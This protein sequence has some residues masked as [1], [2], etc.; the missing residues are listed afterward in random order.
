M[1]MRFATAHL[2]GGVDI[3][4]DRIAYT[5]N[6]TVSKTLD[7][8]IVFTTENQEAETTAYAAGTP[9]TTLAPVLRRIVPGDQVDARWWVGPKALH[10]A[11]RY[12]ALNEREIIVGGDWTLASSIPLLSNMTIRGLPGSS[13]KRGATYSGTTIFV[14]VGT[15]T[16]LE[17]VK[18]IDLDISDPTLTADGFL[19]LVYIARV[20]ANFDA[21]GLWNKNITFENCRLHSSPARL[22]FF[23]YTSD[24]AV[25]GGEYSDAVSQGILCSNVRNVLLDGAKIHDN[26]HG[27]YVSSSIKGLLAQNNEIY[28]IGDFE[29]AGGLGEGD[30][31]SIHFDDT[32]T[33]P[34]VIGNEDLRIRDNDIYRCGRGGTSIFGSIYTEHTGNRVWNCGDTGLNG[35]PDE[36]ALPSVAI[37]KNNLCYKNRDYGIAH[38][39]VTTAPATDVH[40]EA[41]IIDGNVCHNNG[42]NTAAPLAVQASHVPTRNANI[43]AVVITGQ[44]ATD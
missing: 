22:I 31:I 34:D 13:I 36:N 7:G 25:K 14:F 12:G 44:L 21:D 18:F 4:A 5:D 24:I 11:C 27:F 2:P 3:T 9:L 8:G 41:L 35:Q 16:V 28:D 1:P 23:N 38:T 20:K 33:N 43:G 17:N 39:A 26:L 19:A 15:S 10:A 29:G 30:G 6:S 32:E 40:N 42:L 37:Y